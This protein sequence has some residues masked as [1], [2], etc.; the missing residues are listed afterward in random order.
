MASGNPRE[1]TLNRERRRSIIISSRA[2]RKKAL[3]LYSQYGLKT[4]GRALPN[5]GEQRVSRA[6]SDGTN[7]SYIK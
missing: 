7:C 6:K 3:F 1:F 2:R 4:A 5:R